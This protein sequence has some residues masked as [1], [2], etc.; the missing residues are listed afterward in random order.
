MERTLCTLV[1][2]A[3]SGIGREI[4]IHLSQSR[5]LILHGRDLKR[6]DETR[7]LC[8]NHA[9]HEVWAIDLG[10]PSEIEG[11]LSGFLLNQELAVDCFVHSAGVLKIMPMRNMG[12]N[13]AE[14]IMAV[15]FFSAA[16]IVRLLLR[17]SV[18]HRQLRSIVFIS[19]TASKFG[20]RGFNYYC[21]SKGALDSLMRALAVELAPKIRVNSVLPGGVKTPMTESMFDDPELAS[22]LEADYPLGLGELSD[23]AAAVEFLLSDEAGWITGEQLVID[24]GRTV[25]ISA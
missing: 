18:N 3:S 12:L 14:E 7:S 25:N 22:R 8:A 17:R 24:G 6:L 2:G 15:N 21:A 4:A 23:I 10:K 19:S 20:A 9:Q 11:A 1:T 16:E 5:R 13:E